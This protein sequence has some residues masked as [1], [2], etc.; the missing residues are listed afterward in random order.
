MRKTIRK[1]LAV[2]LA[3]LMLSGSFVC[4]AAE[5]NQE[6]ADAHYGQYNNYVLLGDSVACG[7]RDEILEGDAAFNEANKETTYYRV[8]GS[9]ADVLTKAIIDEAN[10]GKMTAL[11]GPGFRTIEMRYML[12]DDFKAE[13]TDPYLFWPSH[14][15]VYENEVCSCHNEN[16][17]PGAEH[18]RALFKKSIAEADLI[19]LGIGGNDW[20][21][22]LRWVI[23]KIL[24]DEHVA[25]KYINKLAET[26]KEGP[27]DLSTIEKAV[28]I[29]HLA[30]ALPTLLQAL[31]EALNY[32][33]GNFYMNWDIMIQD[34]YTL[35]PDVTLM[36]LGMSDNSL[37]GKHYDYNGVEGEKITTEE[38][39]PTKAAVM[40]TIID[41][42][43]GVGNAPMIEGAKKFGYTYVD[44]DG[45]TY[46][47]S[48]PDADG[49]VFIANKIIEALPS[50]EIY[51]KYEDVAP[52]HKYYSE[53]EFCLLNGIL[54]PESEGKFGADSALTKGELTNAINAANGK[55]GRSED[56]GKATALSLALGLLGVSAKKGFVSFF[57]A[58][59]LTYKILTSK[60]FNISASV[61]KAETAY[62]FAQICA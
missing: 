10:G 44:T 22:Y 52:G 8:P 37:K 59:T 43:M 36:V 29:A 62:Y 30:G 45:T 56:G 26:F 15:Y 18:F 28:E 14:L 2:V 1:T 34:I 4:F 58:F 27:I 17:L 6:A 21:A 49:H 53:I 20:G 47:D 41:F 25:D 19:T 51:G 54:S 33:L 5:L 57:K 38:T 60:N 50:K 40:S 46:V 48:H 32:G 7:Y 13:C 11:A 35:N 61:T 39:D 16:L 9:Y 3:L 23:E 12:E 55:D 31:P 24:A 42:I